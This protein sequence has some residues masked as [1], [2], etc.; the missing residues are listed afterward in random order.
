MNHK[1][2]VLTTVLCLILLLAILAFAL[3]KHTSTT[4]TPT[5]HQPIPT[6]SQPTLGQAHATTQVIIFEDLK[7][8]MCAEY[9]KRLFPIIQPYIKSG[10]VKYTMITL[11]FIPGSKPAAKAALCLYHENRA[12]FFPFI[13]YVYQH[14][15]DESTDWATIPRLLALAK[16]A[17]PSLSPTVAKKLS[18]CIMHNQGIATRLTHNLSIANTVMNNDIATPTLYINHERVTPLS[19]DHIRTMLQ[20]QTQH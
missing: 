2:I 15:P 7:C 18:D 16:Q 12:Y 9:N 17:I 14:Q 8:P 11:A 5:Q 1:K 4:T 19:A 3:T 13:E 6:H 10:K 20:K